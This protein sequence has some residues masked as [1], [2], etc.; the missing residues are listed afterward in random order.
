MAGA[1][2]N[3]DPAGK[4]FTPACTM[5]WN[6]KKNME[7]LINGARP[8]AKRYSINKKSNLN[9]TAVLHY[10]CLLQLNCI[11]IVRTLLERIYV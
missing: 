11:S 5:C 2:G 8:F 1:A 6:E 9:Y 7:V 3:P 10:G 4:G